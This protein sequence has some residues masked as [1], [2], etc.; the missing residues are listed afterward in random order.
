M[1]RKMEPYLM[2]VLSNRLYSIGVEMTNTMLRT[3][4]SQV[5]SSCRDLSTAICDR[6]GNLL[7]MPTSIPVHCGN[8]GLTVKPC[9]EHPDGI[10]EGDLFLNNSPYHGNTHHADYTYI[11][12]VFF[13]GELMFFAVAK[14]HQADCGNSIP[15]TYHARAKDIFE[16]GALDWPCVKIQKNYEDVEDLIRVAK[17]R[18]RVPDIWY[19]DYLAGV[20]SARIGEKRLKEFCEEYDI[21]TIKDFCDSYQE[22]GEKMIRAEI[23]KLPEGEWKYTVYHDGIPGVHEENVPI[24]IKMQVKPKDGDII[25]DLRDNIDSLEWG[26]NLSE[27]TSVS[28]V[29]A[30]ILNHLPSKLPNN[31]GVMKHLK[32]L[33]RE[34]CIVGKAKYPYSSSMCTTDL[35][36]RLISGTQALMNQFMKSSGM[37]EG[38]GHGAIGCSVISGKDSRKND[39][40]YITQI[41]VGLSGGPGVKGHDGYINYAVPCVNGV[42]RVM[43]G[44]LLEQQYPM[45]MLSNEVVQDAIGSGEFDSSPSFKVSFTP[46]DNDV[47]FTNCADG[48]TAAPKGVNGGSDSTYT[49]DYVYDLNDETKERRYLPSISSYALKKGE[50]ICSESTSGGGYGDPLNRDPEKVKHRVREGWISIEKA[51]DTYGVVIDTSTETYSVN[52]EETEKLRAIMRNKK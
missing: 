46:I 42:M 44:E 14:G 27:A 52:I 16:E 8:V 11:A 40:P 47:I 35:A 50:V 28:S 33:L 34:G 23:E 24:N 18:I 49:I 30:G 10:K 6:Y 37:A 3:A 4:R 21:D 43:S 39:Y 51:R 20:G 5:M 1:K 38:G 31:E 22:Y 36:D 32:V 25:V 13:G 12:P 17:A 19:G 45:L 9:L 7:T 41:L 48:T 29:R 2:S 15:S 26:L